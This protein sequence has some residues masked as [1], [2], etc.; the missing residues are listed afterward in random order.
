MNDRLEGTTTDLDADN[1]RFYGANLITIFSLTVA[2]ILISS[3]LLVKN[4]V[5]LEFFD[6]KV[7]II[8]DTSLGNLSWDYDYNDDLSSTTYDNDWNTGA[9][10]KFITNEIVLKKTHQKI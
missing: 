4:G 8:R 1:I 10:F 7:K 5:L 2:I 9:A 3:I 6:R